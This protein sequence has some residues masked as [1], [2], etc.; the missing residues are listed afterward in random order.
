[1]P[2]DALYLASPD[3]S[4]SFNFDDQGAEWGVDDEGMTRGVSLADLDRDGWLDIAKRDLAGNSLLYVSRCG[5]EGWL[6]V[7]LRDPD[8]M[9]TYG[10]GAVVTVTVGD[11]VHDPHGTGRR[12]GFRLVAAPRAPLRARHGRP[13]GYRS[14]SGG[15]TGAKT[16]S[17]TSRR[18]SR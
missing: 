1:V 18:G 10:V 13:G 3:G 9:N 2:A 11:L 7:H 5:D 14:T 8:S 4:G 15:W 12:H 17:R 16:R 6:T